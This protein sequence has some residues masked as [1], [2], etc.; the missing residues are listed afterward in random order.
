MD[1]TTWWR[2]LCLTLYLFSML[3]LTLIFYYFYGVCRLAEERFSRRTCAS[4]LIP[5]LFLLAACGMGVALAQR[6]PFDAPWFGV[7]SL[8]AALLLTTISLRCF[9]VMMKR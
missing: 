1:A 9:S 7:C 3:C 8:A 2:V 5:A 6:S 4:L